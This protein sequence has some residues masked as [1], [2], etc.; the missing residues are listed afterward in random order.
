VQQER[1]HVVRGTMK[2][3]KGLRTVIAT[4]GEEVVVPP[5]AYHRF[6]NA[7]HQP[8]VVR[9]RVAPALRMEQLYQTAVAL[10]RE[11]RTLRSGMPK[12]LE[13]ALFMREFAQEARPRSHPGWSVRSWRHLSGWRRGA[14][15]T[16]ATTPCQTSGRGGPCRRLRPDQERR[17]PLARQDPAQCHHQQPVPA[18][19][20]RSGYLT[21]EHGELMAK[22]EDLHVVRPSLRRPVPTDRSTEEPVDQGEE[23]GLSLLPDRRRDPTKA[24]LTAVIAGFR[25]PQAFSIAQTRSRSAR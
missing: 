23:H 7:G 21:P 3:T 13:L 16:G 14:A 22:D 8:A 19:E 25:A 15:W 12:P 2:F 9:V 4:P 11:G 10:A 17:P 18:A 24:L 1:F 6:A 20:A 5:G